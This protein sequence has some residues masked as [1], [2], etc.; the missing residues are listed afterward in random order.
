MLN[1]SS[2]DRFLISDCK[3]NKWLVENLKIY[4]TE[5]NKPILNMK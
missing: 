2:V 5:L 3:I 4:E 1:L